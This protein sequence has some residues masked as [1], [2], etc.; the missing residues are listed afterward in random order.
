M[1]SRCYKVIGIRC[2]PWRKNEIG[3][4]R[5]KIIPIRPK[6]KSKYATY[7]EL[8]VE[9]SFIHKNQRYFDYRS[10]KNAIQK[11]SS[12]SLSFIR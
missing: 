7:A 6:E 2:V 10:L 4:I 5:R 12:E 3:L 9:I 8:T 1:P 11:T